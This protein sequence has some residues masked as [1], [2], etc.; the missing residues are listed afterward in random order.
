MAFRVGQLCVLR[1]QF[2]YCKIFG[3]SAHSFQYVSIGTTKNTC[4]PPFLNA[5]PGG[6]AAAQVGTAANVGSKK[7]K[8]FE[9]WHRLWEQPEKHKRQKHLTE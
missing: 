5:P 8:G 1:S 2:I 7:L 3:I 6:D 4:P 9:D